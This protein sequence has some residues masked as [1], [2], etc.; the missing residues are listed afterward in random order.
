MSLLST[1][2]QIE[3]MAALRRAA[4]ERHVEE[5]RIG[6]ARDQ[7]LKEAALRR[8]KRRRDVEEANRVE[9]E[10]I[11]TG[12]DGRKSMLLASYEAERSRVQAEYKSRRAK[13]E[14]YAARVRKEAELEKKEANWE[15]LTLYDAARKKPPEK[16]KD[17]RKRLAQLRSELDTI[18]SEA[19]EIARSRGVRQ[20]EHRIGVAP[21]E[22]EIGAAEGEKP[23][24][25]DATCAAAEADLAAA[26][27]A[28]RDAAQT[29]YD[30]W[31]PRL[32][33]G[34]LP[35]G[36]FL[37]VL[38][39]LLPIAA[40]M[41]GWADWRVYAIGVG[42]AAMA[43]A[44]TYLALA[45]KARKQT[46]EGFAGAKAA[47]GDA[48]QK[49]YA[50]NTLGGLRAKRELI[51][52]RERRDADQKAAAERAKRKIDEAAAQ[53]AAELTQIQQHF[54]AKLAEMRDRHEASL[55][56]LHQENTSSVSE[57]TARRDGRVAQIDADYAADVKTIEEEY[58]A[59]WQQLFERWLTSYDDVRAELRDMRAECQR[60]FP[61]FA[62]TD[63]PTKPTGDGAEGW[64]PP[65]EPPEAIA[66]GKTVIDLAEIEHG[67]S[68]DERLRPPETRLEAPALMNLAEHPTLLV[69]AGGEG[70]KQGVE[71]LRAMMLRLLTAMPPGKVRFTI[72]DPVGLG[73][74]FQAF[75]HLA[76]ADE[77]LI[78][79]RIWSQP[80]DIEE[81]LGRLTNHMETV[82]QKYLRS[83]YE[84][85]HEYN[86]QAGEVA[87]P[88]QVVVAAG[89]PNNFSEL[90][91]RRLVS[92]VTG[93]PRCGVYTLLGVDSGVRMPTDFRLDEIKE[94]AA[95]LDWEPQTRG[96]G[97]FVWRRPALEHL[98]L[99]LAN[100]PPIEREIEVLK[101][102]GQAAKDAVRVEVPFTI[103]EPPAG[104]MWT[105]KCGDELRIPVGRAGA[106]NLQYVRLGKGTSQHLLVAGKTGSGKSTFLHALVTSA[107]MHFSPDEVEFYL[108]DFKKGVE[109]KSYA[110]HRL[111]HARVIAIESEREFG[112]SVLERLD[113]E[114]RV[115]GEKFR[116]A[117][118]QN[119]ADYRLKRP[120]EKVPRVLLIVDEFQELFVEDDRLAQ[121][122]SLLMDRLVRQGRAF[123]M[124]VIL[125][126]QTL[127]G[128]YSIARST[129]GQIAIRVALECSEADAHLI[130]SDERNTAA[131][132]LSRPGEA[133]YNAQNGMV[134]AN[135]PFQV[136]WLPDR[137][138][139]GK[140]DRIDEHRHELDLPR[141]EAI[142]FEGDAPADP[143]KNVPL[144]AL[145]TGAA[146][147]LKPGRTPHAWIGAAV[148]IKP[149]TSVELG[150][151]PGAN[152]L[153]VGPHEGA[154]L[155]M[156]TT[157]V[158]SLGAADPA[159]RLVV[160][161]GSRPGEEAEGVWQRVGDT[162]AG[163]AKIV[164]Q[165]GV[166][167]TMNELSEEL[168]AREAKLDDSS[169]PAPPPI[170]VVLHNA[171]RF[172]ELRKR[173]D[174]FSFGMS[175]DGPKKPD[176]VLGDLLKNGPALGIHVIV[177]CDSYNSAGRLFDRQTMREFALRVVMQMSAADSSHLIDS[178]AASDLQMH[179]ALLYNDETGQAEKFRP[180][181]A[182]SDE[183][184]ERMKEAA[185]QRA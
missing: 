90:A 129:L 149:P 58:E 51:E 72:L 56:D 120:N 57:L 67:L 161:D 117:G 128:A 172:R 167:A 173:E 113:E 9:R 94:N 62:T 155:G 170:Y 75:M 35:G 38:G 78:N 17:L 124:H 12:A 143:L 102:A 154:A 74:N 26:I 182:P 105:E 71:L 132:F 69:T 28:A 92:L 2:R 49:L 43:S 53:S 159:A 151:H 27:N 88:F 86:A 79:G 156:L 111:P 148:A 47:L 8:N 139:A 30:Q 110:T 93:G 152:L 123:G 10:G 61:D 157:A 100:E 165:A 73:D 119:L 169:A 142:V 166:A 106:K 181:G 116:S 162:L 115:R 178:P 64:R 80:R 59:G 147:P 101:R 50:T 89:F 185:T 55:A 114:L 138:R 137:E 21:P 42:A 184:L 13:A 163:D 158:V 29:L 3:L 133:I 168:A 66:F 97:Q 76:D 32:L 4:T 98:P 180:Y 33:G 70:R 31:L 18:A 54:P 164:D 7:A 6:R 103:V 60:L 140:L 134:T 81:Q 48:E 16:L 125:G 122:S 37:L 77:Q 107:A 68:E 24:V 127:A 20:A 144:E 153:C 19:V 121:E 44:A 41:F 146:P 104:Q 40:T 109:F 45:S 179:R 160:F 82:L 14:A 65:S 176:A 85:I 84:T 25:D 99:E 95:W 136:V 112:L 130:L 5:E 175:S 22:T 39:A 1:H 174:D 91:G 23:A 34:P 63:Y 141:P 118:V 145:L 183:W 126:T 177:W 108:V 52:L 87:E 11:D 15:I 36:V 135:E 131:R 171:G 150:R 83:E 96:G 46:E